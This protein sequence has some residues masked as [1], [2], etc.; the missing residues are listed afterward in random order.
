MLRNFP[1]APHP[2]HRY[3]Q[4]AFSLVEV[5]VCLGIIGIMCTIALEWYSRTQRD[6]LDRLM[7]QRNAQEIV[8]LGVCAT[9]A[10]A[11]FVKPTDKFGTIQKL[12]LGTTGTT[13]V[14][15]GKVFRLSNVPPQSIVDAMPYVAFE[16]GLLLYDPAGGH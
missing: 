5:L 12:V 8:S 4:R 6:V 13:G 16:A 7:N 10:G 15:K 11:D 3:S 14:W 1:R 2:A 9:V